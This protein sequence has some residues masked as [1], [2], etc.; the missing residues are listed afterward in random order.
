MHRA[1]G[2][3]WGVPVHPNQVGLMANLGF[4]VNSDGGATLTTGAPFDIVNQNSGSWVDATGWSTAKG[5]TVQQWECS[6]GTDST[7]ANQK[8][9]FTSAGN[10]YCEVTNV[11]APE[12]AWNGVNDGIANGSLMRL[13]TYAG[14]P[15]VEWEAVSLGNGYYNFIG[16]GSGLCLDTPSAPTA[17]GV[18]LDI[19]TSNGT[20]AQAFK[21]VSPEWFAS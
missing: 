12:E 16:K 11:D 17:N 13:W 15:N 6:N 4:T 9:E 20:A 21:L 1:T 10:G 7:A 19:Y 8:W 5:A 3:A 18:Q 2:S 14:N